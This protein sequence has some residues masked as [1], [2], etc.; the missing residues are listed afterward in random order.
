MKINILYS[1]NRPGKSI[2]RDVWA[3]SR[4]ALAAEEIDL[5]R[6]KK[7][8]L[9][10][11]EFETLV[12]D[13]TS[14]ILEREIITSCR[15]HVMWAQT[16]RVQNILEF[17]YPEEFEKKYGRYYENCR[18]EMIEK[19][20]T[21]R[22]DDYRQFM[23]VMAET[24]YCIK[25][26]ARDACKVGKYF[27]FLSTKLSCDA[28]C[29]RFEK[30][31]E[32]FKSVCWF[33]GYEDDATKSYSPVF[34]LKEIKN[35]HSGRVGDFVTVSSVVPL[36][37]R[38]HMVRHRQL[39]IADNLLSEMSN[40]MIMFT[41]LEMNVKIQVSGHVEDFR[42]VV[43]KR[44]CWIAQYNLWAPFLNKAAELCG[45][46]QND[47]PCARGVCP[48]SEDAMARYTDKDPNAPCPIH[49]R[50]T[51]TPVT[52]V[53]IAQMRKQIEQDDR[54]AFVWEPHIIN[55]EF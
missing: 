41:K 7:L 53:H 27:E 4:P 6:I 11:N 37:L 50:L 49:A 32:L 47:L 38:A 44:S 10:V 40:E 33:A 42:N 29:E 20:K 31:S 52:D 9:P 34:P 23:P 26:S 45:I 21:M 55:L 54:P 30:V 15:N 19:S 36:S 18:A 13:I 1:S 46:T 16:S 51:Q 24:R 14:T 35:F 12:L 48:F 3:I 5:E 28:L 17:T 2:V 8:D 25:I 39:Q 43:G 22:Q